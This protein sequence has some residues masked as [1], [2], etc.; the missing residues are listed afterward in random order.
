MTNINDYNSIPTTPY[1]KLLDDIEK[2]IQYAN[3]LTVPDSDRLEILRGA[4]L[5]LLEV[6]PDDISY[7]N[8]MGVNAARELMGLEPIAY[9]NEKSDD[10]P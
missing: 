9:W 7:P 2:Q 10:N 6:D 4:L 8:P 1:R 5:I 3:S